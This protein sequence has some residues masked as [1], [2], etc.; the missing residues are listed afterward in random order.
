MCPELRAKRIVADTADH[1]H[2]ITK[3]P[4]CDGLICTFTAMMNLKIISEDSLTRDWD[5]LRIGDQ[6]N[7]DAAYDY[8]WLAFG[9]HDSSIRKNYILYSL[10]DGGKRD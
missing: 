4:G 2:R 8:D 1:S 3:P 7:V 6:V 9:K 10:E 5:P